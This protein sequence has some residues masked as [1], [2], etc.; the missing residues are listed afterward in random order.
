MEFNIGSVGSGVDAV[1]VSA[2]S[3][4]SRAGAAGPASEDS[5][6]VDAIPSTPPPEVQQAMAA[7]AGSNA[8]LQAANRELSF[9]LNPGSGQ[10]TIEVHDLSGR[11]LFTVPPSGALRA[12]EFG[13]VD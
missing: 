11:L 7:A 5:V 4:S 1:Q 2:A 12:A 3:R 8:K 6:V 9:H 13:V 10:L